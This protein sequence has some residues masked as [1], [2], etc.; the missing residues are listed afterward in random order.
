MC[1]VMPNVPCQRGGDFKA[2]RWAFSGAPVVLCFG[3]ICINMMILFWSLANQNKSSRLSIGL[4]SPS[5]LSSELDILGTVSPSTSATVN[6]RDSRRTTTK[7]KDGVDTDDDN[8]ANN[9]GDEDVET[10]NLKSDT[11]N[12][13]QN[14][15]RSTIMD[16]QST[17]VM[18]LY[19]ASKKK[20]KS[21]N[22]RNNDIR[23]GMIQALLYIAGY[24]L[25]YGF[26]FIWLVLRN[27]FNKTIIPLFFLN[28]LF[29]PVQGKTQ[30]NHTHTYSNTN[31]R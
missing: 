5:N 23:E 8:C 9:D 26:T 24:F 12:T 3:I 7:I 10:K 14:I 4:P 20:K 1:D 19:A 6:I 31:S 2:I 22:K 17:S 11:T 28:K 15:T 27:V 16:H 29:H 18:A 25:S 13:D 21:S 30:K